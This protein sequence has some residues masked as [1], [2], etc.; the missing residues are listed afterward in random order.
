MGKPDG[1][2]QTGNW[3]ISFSFIWPVAL[4]HLSAE[5]RHCVFIHNQLTKIIKMR[6]AA[7]VD[8][9]QSEIV[10]LARTM[11]CSVQPL[12]TVGQGVPD[13]LV[14]ISGVTDLWEIKD[15]SKP[16]S[17]QKLTIDQILWHDE[18]RGAQVQ[19]INSVD[20]AIARINYVRRNLVRC[21]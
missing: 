20:K 1:Q 5:I 18:W 15:G 12:H 19:V 10:K 11:G 9:N 16:P 7:A 2:S 21:C 14:G 3:K 17:K 13:L 8:S 4:W 6:R